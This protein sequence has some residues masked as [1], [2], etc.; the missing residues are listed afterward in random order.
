MTTSI[1]VQNP[2]YQLVVT[3][4][5]T[6]IFT[7]NTGL[8]GEKGD[9]GPVGPMGP[10]GPSGAASMTWGQIT[11][12]LSAQNDLQVILASKY[13]A[14]NP[15]GYITSAALTPYLTIT[16]ASSTYATTTYVDS[17]L[18]DYLK[19][20]E[21]Q[22]IYVPYTGGNQDLDLTG[23]SVVA[24]TGLFSTRLRL[25]GVDVALNGAN[26]STFSNNVGYITSSALTPYLLSTT[27]A[28]TYQPI[29]TGGATTI[30]GA[31]LTASRA[32]ISNA[33]GKVAVSTVTGTEL[34][35]LSGLT[36]SAQTQLDNRW[37]LDCLFGA[38]TDGDVTIS[39]GTTTLTRTM[40]YNNLTLN[41]TG[42]IITQ[43]NAIYVRGTLN[44]T[45]AQ[46]GAIRNNGPNGTS[47]ASQTGGA[48]AQAT[49]FGQRFTS[50]QPGSAGGTGTTTTGPSG[51]TVT[52]VALS[53]TNRGTNAGR[54]GAG[55]NGSGGTGGISGDATNPTTTYLPRSLNDILGTVVII[56]TAAATG[57]Y[58]SA[59]PSGR[60]GGA[61][62][63]DGTNL[64][65]GG[66]GGGAG[67]G[68]VLI[69]ANTIN[70]TGAIASVI[71]SRGGNGGNGANG[72]VGNVGGGGGGGG[73]CGG[74]VC[75]VYE[76][77]I[78]SATGIIDITGGDGGN[79]GNGIGTGTAG[80]GGHSGNAGVA[81]LI[82]V[83][84]GAM[85]TL[86][87]LTVTANTGQT[88]GVAPLIR[89]SL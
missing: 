79:G 16:N 29:I 36:S 62:G 11:G 17:N 56:V 20:T 42:A 81:V 34:G 70:V 48:G 59:A 65:R 80:T 52:A 31:N 89:Q 72:A 54:S 21:A 25:G 6:Q 22:T 66:G 39:S 35:Y 2:S 74:M 51:A 43:G 23:Y 60:G 57:Q 32:L 14:S 76:E 84:T 82:N 12:T 18:S 58:L 85:S 8:K 49:V 28:S 75:I 61:G 71:S 83:R 1:I 64:G 30:T 3:R 63:G 55:G 45:G 38:G 37:H 41:G 19:L 69:F 4:P 68:C 44:L 24:D 87:D 40:F 67:G 86:T 78:G 77:I 9:T 47:S 73:G 46:A 26:I 15:A 33:S 7:M 27:A 5:V 88:G 10:A 53:P 13:D 50:G